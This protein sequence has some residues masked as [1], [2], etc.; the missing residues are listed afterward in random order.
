MHVYVH[1]VRVALRSACECRPAL[2]H[3]ALTGGGREGVASAYGAGGK[4]GRAHGGAAVLPAKEIALVYALGIPREEPQ[5]EGEQHGDDPAGL[6]VQEDAEH[7]RRAGQHEQHWD[8]LLGL[9]HREERKHEQPPGDLAGDVQGHH[10]LPQHCIHSGP[11]TAE[12][13]SGGGMHAHRPCGGPLV[14]AC[15]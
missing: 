1:A 10:K 5:R 15:A 14:A 3:G 2:L 9:G 7:K 11:V 13:G 6:S 4:G 12:G 8:G